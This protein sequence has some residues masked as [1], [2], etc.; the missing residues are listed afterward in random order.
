MSS[1]TGDPGGP[2]IDMLF[3]DKDVISDSDVVR[4]TAFVS[5]PDGL[6][7]IVGGALLSETGDKLYG[8][9]IQVA[10]GTYEIVLSWAEIH[11]IEP[12]DFAGELTRNLVV[13][14][15]DNDGHEG[16][17]V[18]SLGFACE[19]GGVCDGVCTD[20]TSTVNCQGCGNICDYDLSC[21]TQGCSAP[22]WSPCFIG[23]EMNCATACNMLG[24]VCGQ[25]Q[26]GDEETLRTFLSYEECIEEIGFFPFGGGVC[27]A[28]PLD[29]E[30]VVYSR[31]C[32]VP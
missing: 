12:L 8:P 25:S 9:F 30:P 6:E 13:R 26:C 4:V 16:A 2:S 17:Q 32:C 20:F 31:C 11:E 23:S 15:S 27:D 29:P 10:G 5:D 24:Q 1:T 22:D 28:E 14:F 7:D 18:A 3:L 19:N 21:G